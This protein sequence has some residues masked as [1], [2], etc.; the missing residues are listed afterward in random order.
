[1]LCSDG[2]KEV[3]VPIDPAGRIV[4]PKNIRRQLGLKP[5]DLLRVSRH[6][7]GVLLVPHK[8]IS[9]LVKKGKALVFSTAGENL[10]EAGLANRILQAGRNH[11]NRR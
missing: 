6:G 1:M 5:G 2:M 10:L 8:E 11:S 7:V 9:G 3:F 4:L